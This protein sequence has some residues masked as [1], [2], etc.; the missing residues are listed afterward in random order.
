MYIYTYFKNIFYYTY[1]YTSNIRIIIIVLAFS[2]D[3]ELLALWEVLA[4]GK[5]FVEQIPAL[6]KIFLH[7]GIFPYCPGIFSVLCQVATYDRVW[8][9][10]KLL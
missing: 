1:T 10:L 4:C 3:Y 8:S 5:V 7:V 6:E 2:K 9:S